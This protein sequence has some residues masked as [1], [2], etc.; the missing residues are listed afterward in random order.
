VGIGIVEHSVVPVCAWICVG[1]EKH[2]V[3]VCITTDRHNRT[4]FAVAKRCI[5]MRLLYVHKNKCM[6]DGR[7]DIRLVE[8]VW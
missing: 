8:N 5:R 1:Y 3:A 7:F 2:L 6:D 4:L